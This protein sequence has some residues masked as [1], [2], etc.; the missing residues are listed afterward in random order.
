MTTTHPAAW[1]T[2]TNT[3]TG[4]VVK[5]YPKGPSLKDGWVSYYATKE[6]G[7][8]TGPI[9]TASLENFYRKHSAH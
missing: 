6:D 3:K 8:K 2:F 7:T 4:K 5:V 1:S 9:L